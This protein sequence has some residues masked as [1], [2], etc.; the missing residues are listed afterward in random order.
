MIRNFLS[1]VNIEDLSNIETALEEL[2]AKQPNMEHP[3]FQFVNLPTQLTRPE[4]VEI[5]LPSDKMDFSA[6][7]ETTFTSNN[8]PVKIN[9]NLDPAQWSQTIEFNQNSS[10]VT[11]N[12]NI[13]P[14]NKTI[15]NTPVNQLQM[16]EEKAQ[17]SEEEL[18]DFIRR[19][20]E[21]ASQDQ[22]VE[23]TSTKP[24]TSSP[25]PPTVSTP[26]TPSPLDFF[27][28]LMEKANQ[29][30]I[31]KETSSKSTIISVTTPPPISFEDF[32]KANEKEKDEEEDTSSLSFSATVPPQLTHQDN[33]F[34]PI[35]A[36]S[37]NKVQTPKAVESSLK[38]EVPSTSTTTEALV[39]EVQHS[40]AVTNPPIF[41]TIAFETFP[42]ISLTDFVSPNS[43]RE[44]TQE[45]LSNSQEP[46]TISLDK[47]PPILPFRTTLRTTTTTTSTTTTTTTTTAPPQTSDLITRL[48]SEAAAP[49]AG[50]SAATLA[51]SAAAMLPIWLPVA[52][53]RK[54]RSTEDEL[55]KNTVLSALHSTPS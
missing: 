8:S 17:E 39:P 28:R 33:P 25:A 22:N 10:A 12:V 1:S 4:T 13:V 9:N 32:L 31:E 29:Q 18:V 49:L 50:L 36:T 40:T 41:S 55:W 37:K 34:F 27:Q 24:S 46:L 53:G 11:V 19:L 47:S 16:L 5:S 30:K 3:S 52:L 54:R 38:K 7:L 21:K 45:S 48:L 44:D 14:L 20:M 23:E 35:Q 15:L 6:P 26:S 2:T 51:Y 43:L 42:K